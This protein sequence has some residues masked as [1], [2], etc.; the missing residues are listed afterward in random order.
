MKGDE[1]NIEGYIFNEDDGSQPWQP[2]MKGQREERE[3][4][5]PK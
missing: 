2:T 5:S 4:R 3:E 1:K